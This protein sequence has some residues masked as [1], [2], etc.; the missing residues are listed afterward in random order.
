ME[1]KNT[2]GN[3]SLMLVQ[4]GKH[5]RR[6]SYLT[7]F[8]FHPRIDLVAIHIKAQRIAPFALNFWIR[9]HGGFVRWTMISGR[10]VDIGEQAS[11]LNI[12][13]VLVRSSESQNP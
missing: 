2:V 1:E 7:Q 9:I 6:I 3:G 5:V 13:R 11:V 10:G 8:A 4:K 12:P